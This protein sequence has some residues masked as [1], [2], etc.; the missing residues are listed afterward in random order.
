MCGP[1][2][3]GSTSHQAAIRWSRLGGPSGPSGPGIEL[4]VVGGTDAQLNEF[5]WQ[6]SI[7]KR[8][9]ESIRYHP[10]CGGVLLTE[11]WVMTAAHCTFG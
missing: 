7:E 3:E 10:F 9:T 5:P 6:V 4:R 1:V 8:Q 11:L 2:K